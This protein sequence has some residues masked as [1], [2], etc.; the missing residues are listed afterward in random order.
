MINIIDKK[1]CCGC[2]ACSQICPT[3]A[4]SM[5]KDSEGFLYPTVSNE[6]CI[7]CDACIRV[8]PFQ[9]NSSEDAK[10][11]LIYAVK[12]QNEEVRS[13][14]SSG[15]FFSVICEK[16][17][18]IGGVVFG[19]AFDEEFNVL[20]IEASSIDDCVAFRGA[21]YV[22]SYMG[23]TFLNVKKRLKQGRYVLFSGT[24]CQVA[25]LKKYMGKTTDL[26]KL[27]T[28]DIVCHGVPSPLVWKEYLK[29]ISQGKQINHVTFRS[30]KKGWHHSELSVE[31][32]GINIAQNHGEN[33][34]SLLYFDHYTMR[35][36]CSV[37][38]FACMKREGDISIGDFWGIE[39]THPAFDDDKGVSLV[40]VNSSKGEK[41]FES[42]RENLNVIQS[43]AQECV[44][45]NLMG[46]SELSGARNDFWNDFQVNGIEHSIK[47]FTPQGDSDR[48]I[49][50]ERKIL[51]IKNKVRKVW[52]K[53]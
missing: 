13:Y 52:G 33:P 44:Q 43:N 11:N 1:N 21:K 53:K 40:M 45:P 22:Q 42:I 32:D 3:G 37:C 7:N 23:D 34:Y 51:R 48:R 39:K 9:K 30:K 26:S 46:P 36:S 17:I 35:P 12:N 15:G 8:C 6:R 28:C 10:P 50:I 20:H 24:P 4:I 19:A 38:P 14:S 18:E 41:L 16:V 47:M 31:G 5:E 49:R 27:I 25:G 29:Y 2:T